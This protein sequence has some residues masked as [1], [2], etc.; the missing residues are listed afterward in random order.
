MQTIWNIL[1]AQWNEERITSGPNLNSYLV[2]NK[3]KKVTN[4]AS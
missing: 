1:N 3:K 2:L 4:F